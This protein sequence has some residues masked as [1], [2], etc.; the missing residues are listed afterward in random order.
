MQSD[1]LYGKPPL[2]EFSDVDC[3]IFDLDNTLYPRHVDLFK[4]MEVKMNEFVS[5]LLDLETEKASQLRHDYYIKYG[6]TMRGLMVEH[7]IQ[8]DDFLEFVH[9]IDHSRVPPDPLLAEGIRQLPGK[10]YILTNGTQDHAEKVAAR[11]GITGLFHDIFD[12]VWA[13]LDP[14]PNRAPYDKL[15]AQ[16]GLAPRRAAMFEDLPRNLKIPHELGMKTILVVPSHTRDVFHE[17]WEAGA[18]ETSHVQFITESL[19]EFLKDMR[20]SVSEADR[21]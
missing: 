19:G 17:N 11:L 9:D 12:I 1:L 5:R 7:H 14:K 2:S 20:L 4:Q 15:L 10:R 3:W 8:P 21:R 16:T 13:D 18:E 6:T